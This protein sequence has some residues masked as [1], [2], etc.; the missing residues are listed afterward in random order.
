[1]VG[2]EG[3]EPSTRHR[4]DTKKIGKMLTKKRACRRIA[5]GLFWSPNSV[6][7]QNVQRVSRVTISPPSVAVR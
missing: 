6:E 7:R 1:M 5:V 4:K 3:I 2:G